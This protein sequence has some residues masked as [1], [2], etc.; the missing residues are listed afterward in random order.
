MIKVVIAEDSLVVREYLKHILETDSDIKVIGMA[1]DGDEAV[2][3]VNS[4]KPDVVIMDINMPRMNGFQATRRIMETTPVP[5]VIVSASCDTTE[6]AITFQALEAGALTVLEKPV[7]I[8]DSQ[9]KK[10]ARRFIQTVKVMS[11]VKVI[12]RR[13]QFPGNKTCAPALTSVNTAPPKKIR[14]VAIGGS[15]GGTLVLES[16]FLRIPCQFPV[17]IV[18]V[19]HIAAGF[20][21]GLAEWLQQTTGFP[22]HVA[23]HGE[24]LLP[25]RAY[26]APDDFQMEVKKSMQVSLV[27]A[28]KENG[29]CPSVSFLFRSA[30]QIFNREAIGVLLTGMGTDGAKELKLMKDH[31]AITIAQDEASSL[32]FGMPGKAVELDAAQYVLP[33]DRIVDLLLRI[34]KTE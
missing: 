10:L 31:G 18:I 9:D 12:T 25:G 24:T 2:R 26:F 15:T 32:I 4:L 5:I 23:T 19:Q 13:Q 14:L 1:N 16:M 21:H 22:F 3:I 33:P 34:T 30:A 7:G 6:A 20:V 8:K 29:L 17:P 27:K 11:E 28:E